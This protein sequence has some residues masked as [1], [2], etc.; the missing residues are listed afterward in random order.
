MINITE[1]K[2][3]MANLKR[4]QNDPLFQFVLQGEPDAMALQKMRED[5][6]ELLFNTARKYKV[7]YIFVGK[8]EICG[9]ESKNDANAWPAMWAIAKVVGFPGSCGNHDQYQC[10]DS[11]IVFP[12][13]SYGA[14]DLKTNTKLSAEEAEPMKFRRVVTR[15]RTK[16]YA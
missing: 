2:R 13:D 16:D 14:W 11:D 4:G 15:D 6:L 1:I 12:T 3:I 10:H 5:N 7:R 9:C 8:G